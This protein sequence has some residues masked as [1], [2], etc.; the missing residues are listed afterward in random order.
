[1]DS[2]R[3]ERI[4]KNIVQLSESISHGEQENLKK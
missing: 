4:Y 2:R 1:V 3:C